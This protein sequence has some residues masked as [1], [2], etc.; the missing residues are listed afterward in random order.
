MEREKRYEDR[1]VSIGP[2]VLESGEEL[3]SVELA[4]ERV[5]PTEAPVILVCHAL[6]GNQYTV[7]ESEPG[8]W[9]GLIGHGKYVDTSEF[10]VITFNVLGGCN[11]STGPLSINPETGHAYQSDFPFVTVRD[12]VHSQ[13]KALQE[14]GVH[15]LH[16][17]IGGSLGG[18]QV[19]EWGILYPDWMDHL[20][21]LA[22][23]PSLSAYGIA[24][25]SISRFAITKD[26]AWKGGYYNPDQ[27]PT[28]GLATAR[29][30]GM[31]SYRTDDMFQKKFGRNGN[32]RS[33]ESHTEASYDVESYL[34][35]Q[36]N[37]LTHRFDAN[38]YLYLLKAMD[39]HDIGRGRGDIA[40]AA[41]QIQSNVLAISF[42]GDLIYPPRDL[43]SMFTLESLAKFY[44]VDTKFGHD[45]F[46]VE[47]DKWGPLIKE[48]LKET[49][50][51]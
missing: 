17:V 35:Y 32:G 28:A 18:M 41:K 5:G 1:N 9:K 4:Y 39:M 26:P 33:G 12:I 20:V 6:T 30:V 16:A 51:I 42:K 23:T 49:L 25:N 40:R 48:Q 44:I 7:G 8:W 13:N 11:G 29:M 31:I 14:L 3:P 34:H 43:D 19:L 21:P 37:K 46:L 24:Y 22:V 36:G 27:P 15:H 10:Q 45:G 2:F 47:F 50:K 38:S